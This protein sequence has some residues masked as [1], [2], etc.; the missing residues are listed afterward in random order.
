MKNL[1]L[2]VVASIFLVGTVSAQ[3]ERMEPPFWWANMP[4]QELQIKLYGENLGDYRASLDYEGVEITQQIAV[5]SKNYLFLYLEVSEDTQPGTIEIE[6]LKGRRD[7][8]NVEFE[9]MERETTEGKHM[10]FDASDLIYLMMPDRFANGNPDNDSIEGMLETADVTDPERRQGGDL[11]GVMDH[12]DYIKEQGMTAIWLM[13]IFENDMTPEYGGY[14]GYAATDMYRV[15]RRFGTNDEYK[16]LVAASHEQGMKVI[17]DM[18][19]N[20]IG[21]QHWCCLLYTSPSPRD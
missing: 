7:R 2:T 19:H 21:D 10:G 5:D 17:M 8:I 20:H 11:Q 14:H 4:V 18:I 13:P 9:L 12:L 1:F 16:A 3:V 6:L 15:D